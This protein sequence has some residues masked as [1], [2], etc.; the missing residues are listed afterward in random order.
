MSDRWRDLLVL[1]RV[2]VNGGGTECSTGLPVAANRIL[3]ARHGL[4]PDAGCVPDREIQIEWFHQPESTASPAKVPRSAIVWEDREL[5][6]AL[7]DC[8][9]PRETASMALS[10][11]H[12]AAAQR[13]VGQR[14]F[15]DRCGFRRGTR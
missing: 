11:S 10:L 2:P 3:T 5:D 15:P 14:G 9:P 8:P 12:A 4:Y 7:I 6:A 1:I 13:G